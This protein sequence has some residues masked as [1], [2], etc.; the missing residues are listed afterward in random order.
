MTE[1]GALA[2]RDFGE[3]ASQPSPFLFATKQQPPTNYLLPTPVIGFEHSLTFSIVSEIKGLFFWTAV[4][5]ST[6]SVLLRLA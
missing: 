5:H 1:A 4:P 6:R 2:A 3:E